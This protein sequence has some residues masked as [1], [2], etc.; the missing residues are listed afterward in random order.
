[1]KSF[2]LGIDIGGTRVKYG[3]INPSGTV[4]ARKYLDTKTYSFSKT[5]LIEAVFNAA[6]SLL[7]K[8]RLTL[9]HLT[10]V[11]VGVPGLVDPQKGLVQS[12]TNIPGWKNIP[13]KQILQNKFRVPV[14]IEN[15]VNL[16]TLAEWKF[17]AGKGVKN[18]VCFTLGTGVGGGLII[19]NRLYRGEGFAAGEIGHMPINRKGP[20]CNCGGWACFE[21]YV[22]NRYLT[23]RAT[24]SF[25]R[26]IDSPRDVGDMAHAGKKEA[27]RFWEEVGTQIGDALTGVVNLLN[28]RMIIIGGGVANNYTFF[29]PAVKQ[30]IKERAMKIP[31][32]QVRVVRASLGD[33]AGI[34]GARVL[35]QESQS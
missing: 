16:I 24:R 1:M 32:S 5:S 8:E 14:L 11:G 7:K 4:V 25:G 21:R 17:G 9:K 10:G 18:L 27:L 29:A 12:L 30:R 13:L 20:A 19:D 34:I 28:P 23:E 33:N 22:G 35:V 15:D 31:A 2:V 6:V 3:L 26:K